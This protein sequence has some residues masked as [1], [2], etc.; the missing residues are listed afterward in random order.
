MSMKAM[1]EIDSSLARE[2]IKIQNADITYL[3]PV[4]EEKVKEGSLVHK[5]R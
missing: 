2:A 3:F 5:V 4:Y 1:V